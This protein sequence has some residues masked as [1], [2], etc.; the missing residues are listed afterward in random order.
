MDGGDALGYLV[1]Y[2]PHTKGSMSDINRKRLQWLT[3]ICFG[4]FVLLVRQIWPEESRILTSQLLP[5]PSRPAQIAFS[6]LLGNLRQGSGMM[7]SLA[8]F[9]REILYEIT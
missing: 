1:V 4:L 6:E 2:G 3:V 9:C 7:E 8:V 5:E